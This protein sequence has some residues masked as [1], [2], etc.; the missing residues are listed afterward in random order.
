MAPCTV[1]MTSSWGV[2]RNLRTE[3]LAT[4]PT[5]VSTAAVRVGAVMPAMPGPRPPAA[6]D[7]S[8]AGAVTVMAAASSGGARPGE[9][10]GGLR[11]GGRGVV[12]VDGGAGQGEE[13]L[14][15]RGPA[16]PDVVDLDAEAVDGPDGLVHDGPPALDGHG[17]AAGGLVDARVARAQRGQGLGQAGQVAHL[18]GVQLD[19][20]APGEGLELAGGALGDDPAV[21]DD[22][23]LL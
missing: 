21:V 2:R 12:G 20:V 8:R 5:V 6:A 16:Q 13:D 23:D 4:W 22:D 10:G 17:E 7:G 19:D 15:E 18:V 1:L 14:V 11:I 9:V 3:R